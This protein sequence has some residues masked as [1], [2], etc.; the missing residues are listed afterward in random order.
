M[1]DGTRSDGTVAGET[2]QHEEKKDKNNEKNNENRSRLLHALNKISTAAT[3]DFELKLAQS[4]DVV[5]R[6]LDDFGGETGRGLAISFNGGKDAC[7]VLYLLLFVLAQRDE[8]WRLTSS[9]SKVCES[10]R[11]PRSH[12]TSTGNQRPCCLPRF[13]SLVSSDLQTITKTC[14]ADVALLDGERILP[15][16]KCS[17]VLC[18]TLNLHPSVAFGMPTQAIKWD[19][20]VCL[21]SVV[22]EATASAV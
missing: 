17:E 12:Q 2:F 8:L 15:T 1:L 20:L 13:V 21:A 22:H 5:R 19:K 16:V 7:V 6:A 9:A 4:L 10:V 11:L 3:G 14:S 18:A